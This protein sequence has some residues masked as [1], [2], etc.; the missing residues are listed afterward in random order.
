[1]SSSGLTPN[2]SNFNPKTFWSRPEGGPG[3]VLIAALVAAGAYGLYLALPFLIALTENLILLG[4]L[5]AVLIGAVA[6]VMNGTVQSLAKNIF[7]SLCRGIA[8]IYTEIDPV[9]IL[10]NQLDDMKRAKGKLDDTIQKFAGSDNKLTAKIE[11]KKAKIRALFGKASILERKLPTVTDPGQAETMKLQMETWQS[12]AGLEQSGV[13]ALQKLESQT[14]DM[15]DKFR[16]WSRVSDAKID[17]MQIKADFYAELREQ[18]LAAQ[19]TLGVGIRLLKGDPEQLKLVDSAIEFLNDDAERTIG[20]I[21]EFNRFS[22]KMLLDIDTENTQNAEEAR[23]K[24]AE[25]G[26]KL[27]ADAAKPGA[28]QKLEEAMASASSPITIPT[29]SVVGRGIGAGTDSGSDYGSMFNKK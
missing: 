28:V 13:E 20:E 15:L 10:R 17:R 9:G 14:H 27:D 19:K 12:Q 4:A 2:L 26:Q 1:M 29:G 22:D 18:T 24:F 8:M 25:F 23:A 21:N 5:V 7:Q 6:L 11:E 16:H 3:K